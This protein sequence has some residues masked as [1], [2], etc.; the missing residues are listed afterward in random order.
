MTTDTE[1]INSQVDANYVK[2]PLYTVNAADH[3][4]G[5]YR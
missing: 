4:A 5:G 2:A 1:N 3:I